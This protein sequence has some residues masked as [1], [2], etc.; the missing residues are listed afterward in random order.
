[1]ILLASWSSRA[2][3]SSTQPDADVQGGHGKTVTAGL[4]PWRKHPPCR[5]MC[6]AVGLAAAMVQRLDGRMGVVEGSGHG[7]IKFEW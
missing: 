4:P 1:M 5:K 2:P 3:C 6:L 7:R